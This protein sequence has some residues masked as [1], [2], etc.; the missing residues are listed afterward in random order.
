MR[1]GLQTWGTDGDFYPFLALS[2]GLRDAGHEVT[3]AYTSV[4]G[5]KYST[6]KDTYGIK[7]IEANGGRTFDQ[8]VNPYAIAARSGSFREYSKLLELYFDP[9]SEVMYSV[10]KQLC[11]ENEL[12]IGHA[13]CHTL[14]TA[15][16]K[17]NCPRIS[18]VLTPL[19]VR[20]NYVSPIGVQLGF[21]FNSLLWDTGGKLATKSWFKAAKQI[22]QNEGLSPIKS[23]Q[24]ELFTSELLTI[25]AASQALVSRPEDWE[26][27]V[28]M[29]GFLNLP[30]TNSDWKMPDALSTFLDAG[31]PPVYMTFG[32]C[33]QFDLEAS[34]ELLIDT[35][36]L[37]GKRAIIQSDWSKL[38][39]PN[40]SNIYCL[41]NAPHSE[42][43]PHCALI[44]HHG[45]AGT[46]QAALLTGKLSVVVAHGFDQT[47]WGKQ[48]EEM[49]VAPS[50]LLRKNLTSKQ[51]A[52]AIEVAANSLEMKEQATLLGAAMKQEDGVGRAVRAITKLL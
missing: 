47:Y 17:F 28:Q 50:L 15:S 11:Q 8:S 38:T 23:L 29:T 31:E 45:G 44:V 12:V 7:L 4:D 5:K 48:L 41:E 1:I 46:T 2:I 16:Q 51:L 40:D 22:R 42:I 32:S 35:A 20:S 6:R 18:L 52:H 25:I 34:T 21:F 13:V 10:S 39:K 14:L 36:R 26:D 24:K 49:K 3:L 30:S 27:T 43:F 19:V 37:S 9:L 33:M